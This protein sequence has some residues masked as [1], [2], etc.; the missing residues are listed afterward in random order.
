MA[1][2]YVYSAHADIF[3]AVRDSDLGVYSARKQAIDVA[4]LMLKEFPSDNIFC[5]VLRYTLNNPDDTIMIW[6]KSKSEI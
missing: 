1:T 6:S 3:A 2:K 4:S 5:Y